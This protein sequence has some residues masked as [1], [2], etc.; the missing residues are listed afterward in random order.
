MKRIEERPA[1]VAL[2]LYR[3]LICVVMALGIILIAGTVYGLVRGRAGASPVFS[4]A[5]PAGEDGES[6]FSGMGTL[7]IPTADPE[8]ETLLV[9]IAFPYDKNDRPFSE[10][11]A[12][13]LSFFKTAAAEYLGAF[14]AE[15]LTALD[16]DTVKTELLTRY[17]AAL[18]LGQIRELYILE[19]M[20]L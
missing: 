15:E 20:R 10:E 6:I 8:P 3:I 7:R 13:R 12:S 19:Y 9:S 16:M 5:P 11:L 4:E 1:P 17:N 18:R 2:R 14:S